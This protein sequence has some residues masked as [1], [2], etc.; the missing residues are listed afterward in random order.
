MYSK[1]PSSARRTHTEDSDQQKKL[2]L[3]FGHLTQEDP[4]GQFPAPADLLG[5][6]SAIFCS[7]TLT[8]PLQQKCGIGIPYSPFRT[9]IHSPGMIV[10]SRE[11]LIT[12]KQTANGFTNIDN[13]LRPEID[14]TFTQ[15]V[16]Q[17]CTIMHSQE[18]ASSWL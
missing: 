9:S 16:E 4:T 17:T 15:E 5:N 12:R 14:C 2:H 13:V 6:H 1:V 8:S 7:F 3:P 11:S 10:S 18:Q